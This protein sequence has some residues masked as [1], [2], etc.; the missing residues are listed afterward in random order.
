MKSPEGAIMTTDRNAIQ[1]L[2]TWLTYQRHWCEHKPSVTI[3]VKE[4][5]WMEVGAWVYSNFDELSGV[6]FL[7]YSEH[8]YAQAPY[9]EISEEEYDALVSTMPVGTDWSRISEYEDRDNTIGTQSLACTGTVCE[10]VDL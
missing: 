4:A 7:P 10:I 8:S 1:Q 2:E 3:N 5:E 6:S 9:Q